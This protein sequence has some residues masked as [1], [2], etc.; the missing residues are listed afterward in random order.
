MELSDKELID[1]YL[2]GDE[3][4]FE[5]LYGR[6]RKLLYYFLH[7]FLRSDNSC[8]DDIFQQTWLKAIDNL[9]KYHDDCSFGAYLKTIAKNLIIDQARKRK[10]Q[11]MIFEFNS[12]VLLEIHNDQ[13]SDMP[14]FELTRA[15]GDEAYNEALKILS[16]EQRE[17]YELRC[18]NMSF[19]EIACKLGVSINTVLSRMNYAK[20]K[21]QEFLK[22]KE[23]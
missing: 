2:A 11:G 3:R 13:D 15:E 12:N 9:P 6:Y 18:N 1:K 20:K 4:A 19:K 10:R 8:L 7:E 22:H 21:L 16:D 17:V 23:Q 5:L 14:W